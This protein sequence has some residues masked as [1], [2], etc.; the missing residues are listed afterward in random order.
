MDGLLGDAETGGDVLPR[1]AG[2]PC[3]SDLFGFELFG[4]PTQAGDRAQTCVEVGAAYGLF[5]FG[6]GEHRVSIC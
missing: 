3:G 1:P 4:Q 2:P 6:D 5:N